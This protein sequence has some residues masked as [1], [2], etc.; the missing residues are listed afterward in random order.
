MDAS[1]CLNTAVAS[2]LCMLL[3]ILMLVFLKM[4]IYLHF[5]IYYIECELIV[6]IITEQGDRCC[7]RSFGTSSV[8]AAISSWQTRAAGKNLIN[9]R[10]AVICLTE[11]TVCVYHLVDVLWIT[12]VICMCIFLLHA[13]QFLSLCH[14]YENLL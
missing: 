12:L 11:L 6:V 9:R 14:R 3:I 7:C 2:L 10:C 1:E 5:C 13:P 4:Y 8:G